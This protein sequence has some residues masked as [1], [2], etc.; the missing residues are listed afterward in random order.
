MGHLSSKVVAITGAGAGIGRAVA[1]LFAKES[2]TLVLNDLGCDADGKGKAPS[3]IA[4]FGQSLR[5]RGAELRTHCEDIST[6]QGA[7]SF[8]RLAV[9]EFGRI[10]VLINC[11]GIRREQ[12]LLNMRDKDL[13][14]VLDVQVVGTFRCT[15]AAA[16]A[17]RQQGGGR[18]VNTTSSNALSGSFG[19]SA[20]SAAASAI[21]G[22]TRSCAAELMRHN[23]FVNAVAPLAR[24]RQTEEL[25]LFQK[26][27]TM[28]VDHVARAYLYL[29]SGES[30]DVTGEV[31]SVVGD[32]A[33]FLRQSESEAVYAQSTDG[34]LSL[35]EFEQLSK[36]PNRTA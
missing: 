17:M 12:A 16:I 31:L 22:F 23:I 21:V 8:I 7:E 28:T 33:A 10:D 6:Q 9:V 5:L 2:A 18:I 13:V 36:L 3:I 19:Q 35:A 34:L 1:E 4:D 26:V 14:A 24:T 27:T 32:R 11:A 15:Q 30:R 25:P 29:A 20:N